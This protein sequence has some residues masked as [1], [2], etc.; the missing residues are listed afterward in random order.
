MA[1]A[2]TAAEARGTPMRMPRL[3]SLC[4][5]LVLVASCSS[6]DACASCEIAVERI[7]TF[8]DAEGDGALESLP[9][10]SAEFA[11]RRIVLQPDGSR[12]LPRFFASNGRF[13]SLLGAIGNGPGEFVGPARAF[14]RG[15]TAWIVDGILRRATAVTGNGIT[16]TAAPWHRTA[17][18]A[19]ARTDQSWILAGGEG[20]LRAMA[21]ASPTGS[22][23]REFGDTMGPFG[24]RRYLAD[25]GQHF[26]SA[27][28]LYRLR[29]E[30]WANPDSLVRVI[31]PVTPHFPAYDRV[32]LATAERPPIPALRGFWTDSLDRIWALVE[33]PGTAWRSGHGEPRHGEGGASY[34]P[35]RDPNRAYDSGAYTVVSRRQS[36][37]NA[38]CLQPARTSPFLRRTSRHS[39]AVVPPPAAACVPPV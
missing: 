30:E 23:L 15:D 7:A 18:D 6:H 17:Y 16:K 21:V 8:G 13:L 12:L 3:T 10:V 4:L 11:G 39:V 32:R 31:E 9:L 36:R 34:L 28:S 1:A 37:A 35:I 5:G 29:F 33:V 22:I 26:W 20:Y 14:T 19:I 24:A 38:A 2:A 27:A 25:A